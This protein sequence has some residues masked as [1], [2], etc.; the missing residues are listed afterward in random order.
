ML[1]R[2][3]H[4]YMGRGGV[5]D[6]GRSTSPELA[7]LLSGVAGYVD[8]AGFVA[9]FGLFTAH[10]T[11]DLVAIGV[12]AAV[13]PTQVA[14]G[15]M[16]MLPVFILSVA[17]T[18]CWVRSQRRSGRAPLPA[19]LGLL[20]WALALFAAIGAVLRPFDA[21]HAGVIWVLGASGVAAMAVQ[22][23]LMRDVLPG[24]SPTT[25]MTGNLTQV[26]VDLV[27]LLF[28]SSIESRRVQAVL[29]ERARRRLSVLVPSV[30]AFTAGTV[31]GAIVTHLVGLA[32]IVVPALAVGAAWLRMSRP[33]FVPAG[34][35]PR[36][37]VN[38]EPSAAAPSY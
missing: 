17:A 12:G 23:T 36:E 3:H 34:V 9:L 2:R 19:V 29:R 27:E 31:L 38:A 18:A 14:L 4:Q 13:A 25:I 26:T 11:G 33:A 37:F 5:L 1:S 8:S 20:T 30:A 22:N 15:R 35:G 6:Q 32:S 7:V 21:T 10:V 28:P 16:A 24:S